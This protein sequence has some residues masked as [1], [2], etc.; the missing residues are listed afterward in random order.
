MNKN[1]IFILSILGALFI[2]FFQPLRELIVKHDI[3][4]A[5]NSLGWSML[6]IVPFMAVYFLNHFY[7]IPRMFQKNNTK[8]F[9][10][11]NLLLFIVLY[12]V[13]EI[14]AC[15]FTD[16]NLVDFFTFLVPNLLLNFLVAGTALGIKYYF[17]SV[18][19][20][21][22]EK[23]KQKAELQ[24]LKNQLN[25]HF[26]FNT[27]NNISAQI[28]TNPDE[29]QENLSH[30]SEVLRYALYETTADKVPLSGEIDFMENYISLMKLRCSE[31]TTVTVDFQDITP[32]IKIL[33]LLYVSLI[34][35]AFKHGVSNNSE[36]FI[37]ISLKMIGND[38]VF[39]VKNS[40]FPKKQEN[41]SGS[42]IGLEN[43][44][45]RLELAYE[46]KYY[47]SAKKQDNNVFLAELTVKI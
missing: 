19:E 3:N 47:F 27:M 24:W 18:E 5:V 7:A 33:P 17:K 12:C 13:R 16:V 35:N 20:M 22:I 23:E 40:N 29:A 39:K 26:L 43:L 46:G 44:R 32:T 14:I 8:K 1:W 21:Q 10:L 38:L 15:H 2:M 42:G 6:Y 36:S 4:A 11:F 25:P 45:R 34:E 30:L 31:K 41:R 9:C 37:D 28:Y